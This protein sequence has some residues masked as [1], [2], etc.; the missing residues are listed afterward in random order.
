M[1]VIALDLG[2]TKLA[3]AI[4]LNDGTLIEHKAQLLEKRQGS[5]I[6]ELIIEQILH[7]LNYS[8]QNNFQI[9][10]VGISV[11]GIYWSKKGTVWAPNIPGW[12]DYNLFKDIYE[13]LP[14]KSI[15]ITID[16]DRACYI[17]GEFWQGAARG[18]TDAIFM[19]VGTGIGLGILI[20]GKVLRGCSD[21]AGATGWMALD[22]P[23]R[24]EYYSCGCFEY[25]A[26][27]AG[28]AKVAKE[29][30]NRKHNYDGIL[31][32]KEIEL[33]TAYDIFDAFRSGDEISS[34]VIKNAIELWG[35]AVANYVSLFN[36][37]KIVFGGGIFG[38][39]VQFLDKILSEAKKWAQPISIN[40]VELVPSKLGGKAGIYGAGYLAVQ[41]L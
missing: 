6:C 9:S 23:F 39:A 16:S 7:L 15:K 2:G 27:G 4:F 11:P 10:G 40:H 14:N 29:L 1:N 17:L 32:S 8:T 24:D 20:D 22:R 26:S 19:A 3:S 30:L 18:C 12:E 34:I 35:M 37:Q 5:E 41:S 25:N 21:I 28:I 36:P 33:I 31:R 38:P 13:V